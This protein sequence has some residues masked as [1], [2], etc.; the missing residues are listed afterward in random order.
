M[1][2]PPIAQAALLFLITLKISAL[3]LDLTE[4]ELDKEFINGD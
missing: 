1:Q 4:K 3:T 2:K